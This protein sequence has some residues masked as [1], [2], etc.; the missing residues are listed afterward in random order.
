MN[1]CILT[2]GHTFYS[3][4]YFLQLKVI[5][6]RFLGPSVSPKRD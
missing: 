4:R 2:V 1:G 5:N 6:V 3:Y